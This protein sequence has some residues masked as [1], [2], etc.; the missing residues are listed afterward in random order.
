MDLS[1]LQALIQKST[2]I[3][4][5]ERAYWLQ[6]LPTMKPEHVAKLEAILSEGETIHV[7]EKVHQYFSALR[8]V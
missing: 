4:D 5:E 8:A 2:L 7:D 3:T 1:Q 6:T